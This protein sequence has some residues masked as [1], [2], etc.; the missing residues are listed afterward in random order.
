[1]DLLIFYCL[2]FLGLLTY[3]FLLKNSWRKRKNLLKRRNEKN[4][5]EG[6]TKN[7]VKPY[8]NHILINNKGYALN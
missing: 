5:E 3:L 1:M 8:I 2:L 7:I 6:E 4:G